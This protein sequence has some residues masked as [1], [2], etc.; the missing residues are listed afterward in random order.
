VGKSAAMPPNPPLEQDAQTLEG[1][2]KLIRTFG[3]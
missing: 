3:T 2:V 1:L